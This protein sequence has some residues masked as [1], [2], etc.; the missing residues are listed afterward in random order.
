MSVI[1]DLI[2]IAILIVFAFV[3]LKRGAIRE[4]VSLVGFIVALVLAFT[5]SK[6]GSALIYDGFISDGITESISS[7]ITPSEDVNSILEQLPQE[8]IDAGEKVGIDVKTDLKDDVSSEGSAVM[9]VASAINKTVARP[10]ISGLIQVILFIIIFIAAKIL[11]SWLG[12]LLNVVAKLPI[13]HS[14]NGVIGLVIGMIR[15]IIIAIV[16]CY[17]LSVIIGIYP[18]G[19]FGINEEVLDKSYIFKYLSGIFN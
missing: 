16:A 13:I 6:A 12:K 15:G 14:A 3:G 1:V 19:A 9:S 10:L 11:I 8:I 7:A 5:L 4:I 2:L 17:A 18:E